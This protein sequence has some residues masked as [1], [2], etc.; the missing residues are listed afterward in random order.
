M[1]FW[2]AQSRAGAPGALA[3]F[4]SAVQVVPVAPHPGV[5]AVGGALIAVLSQ[6]G[7]FFQSWMKRRAGVKDSGRLIPGHGGVFDRFDGML[8]VFSVLG[9][10]VLLSGGFRGIA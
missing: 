4:D 6:L 2:A 8:A 3:G 1:F 7:D 9:I 5:Y 10:L